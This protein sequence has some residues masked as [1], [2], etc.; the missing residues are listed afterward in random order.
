MGRWVASFEHSGTLHNAA[1]WELNGVENGHGLAALG[2]G[3]AAAA[4]P[5]T[6]PALLFIQQVWGEP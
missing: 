1:G 3:C 2:L 4:P 6:G 5:F